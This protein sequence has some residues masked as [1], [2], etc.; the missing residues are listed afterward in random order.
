M[1]AMNTSFSSSSRNLSAERV[2]SFG[3]EQE[4]LKAAAAGRRAAAAAGT[5]VDQGLSARPVRIS[6]AVRRSQYLR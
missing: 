1:A 2:A 4:R 5:Q 6:A 3:F